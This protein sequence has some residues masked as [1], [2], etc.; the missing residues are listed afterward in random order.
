MV[1]HVKKRNHIKP[2]LKDLHWLPVKSRINFKI[3]ILTFKAIHHLGPLYI[4]NLVHQY[5]PAR[6]LRSKC[7]L[8][9]TVPRTRLKTY[10]DRAFGHAAPV[11]WNSLPVHIRHQKLFSSFKTSLKAHFFS[12]AYWVIKHY[13]IAVYRPFQHLAP[14]NGP[15]DWIYG[16]L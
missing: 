6:E 4:Q 9:L 14:L 12:Q 15:M 1:A 2:I 16:A 8:H 3:L 10:G 13:I 11:L 5:R 7:D